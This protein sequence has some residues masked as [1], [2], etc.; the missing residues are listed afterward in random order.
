MQWVGLSYVDD[1]GA[2]VC[3]WG[4]AVVGGWSKVGV[5]MCRRVQARLWGRNRGRKSRPYEP[6]NVICRGRGREGQGW[7]VVLRDR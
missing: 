7:G 5:T 2:A 1:V 3:A 4:G 6:S